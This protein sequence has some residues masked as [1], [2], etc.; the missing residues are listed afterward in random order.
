M[1]APSIYAGVEVSGGVP[2]TIFQV[3]LL[4]LLA[5]LVYDLGWICSKWKKHIM[6]NEIWKIRV[7]FMPVFAILLLF[8]FLNKGSLKESTAYECFEYIVSGQAD[9]YRVQM[10]ERLELLLDSGE[11]EVEL[12][13]MNSEQGPLMHMEVTEDPD[14]WTN[15]VVEQFFQKDKVTQ[16]ERKQE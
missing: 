4:L 7:G 12:P 8:L 5:V 1:Y 6:E 3:F 13:A 2:N 15:T 10:D 9:D 16:I 11:K 14:A